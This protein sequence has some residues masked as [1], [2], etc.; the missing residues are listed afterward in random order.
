MSPGFFVQ[1]VAVLFQQAPFDPDLGAALVPLGA[2]PRPGTAQNL[3]ATSWIL[4][5]RPD[6]GGF[7]LVDVL[8]R[9]WPDAFGDPETDASTF[10]AR[11]AGAF[12]PG[13]WPGGLARA[14]RGAPEP[15]ALALVER[16]AGVVRVRLTYALDRPDGAPLFPEGRDPVAELR[17]VLE[18]AGAVLR[19]PGALAFYNPNAEVL[20]T[21]PAFERARTASGRA[22]PWPLVVAIR[23][24]ALEQP[25]GHRLLDTLGLGAQF[26][27]ARF[28]LL[29]HEVLLG[30]GVDP[31]EARRMLQGLSATAIQRGRDWEEGDEVQG[32]GGGWVAQR[33]AEALVV[34]PRPVWRWL[35]ASLM[36]VVA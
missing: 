19:L 31:G 30:D 28:A 12:G 24:L 3:H 4:P 33:H 32:P 26:D 9:P 15:E 1:G 10:V 21:P 16:H 5:F 20:A 2:L 27:R 17:A 25:A 35:P 14:A 7:V 23:E 6:A 36:G 18:V 13:A 11:G 29:D 22:L 8:P 34:P